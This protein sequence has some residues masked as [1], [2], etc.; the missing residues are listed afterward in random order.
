FIYDKLDPNHNRK[1]LIAR[2]WTEIAAEVGHAVAECHTRWRSLRDTFM[3][4]HQDFTME[5]SGESD[6]E[7]KRPK[8]SNLPNN[9]TVDSLSIDNDDEDCSFVNVL[10]GGLDLEKASKRP[11]STI[12]MTKRKKLE[13]TEAMMSSLTKLIDSQANQEVAATKI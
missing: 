12:N 5:K 9:R 13:A 8:D 7:S 4:K 1:K 11:A 2:A 3:K 6:D 10:S